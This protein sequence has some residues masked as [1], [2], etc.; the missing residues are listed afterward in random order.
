MTR[1]ASAVAFRMLLVAFAAVVL[2]FDMTLALA[3]S[4]RRLPVK[5]AADC[6]ASPAL[7]TL[8]AVPA[9]SVPPGFDAAFGSCGEAAPSLKDR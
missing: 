9:P 6:S 5:A 8:A 3:R 1:A 4:T 2:Y 7:A